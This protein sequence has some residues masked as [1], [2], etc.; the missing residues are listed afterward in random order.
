M[1]FE[2]MYGLFYFLPVKNVGKV[3]FSDA[4]TKVH[5]LQEVT[6]QID[7]YGRRQ[8]P[9]YRQCAI[10]V[11]S[12]QQI[13][14]I[15]YDNGL[16]GVQRTYRQIVEIFRYDIIATIPVQSVWRRIRA[17]KGSMDVP[18]A[19]LRKLERSQLMS[20][21][22]CIIYKNEE[23]S[24]VAWEP[25]KFKYFAPEEA[26]FQFT[27]SN[28]LNYPHYKE[29]TEFC[30]ELKYDKVYPAKVRF[31]P[32]ARGS[33]RFEIWDNVVMVSMGHLFEICNPLITGPAEEF[34]R[35]ACLRCISQIRKNDCYW[36]DRPFYASY[37]P[38]EWERD[39]WLQWDPMNGGDI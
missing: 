30:R 1:T 28:D 34:D 6:A 7:T 16:Y 29:I 2:E 39:R 26:Y 15:W 9:G 22:C 18:G 20:M 10:V 35:E 32:D 17:H 3:V 24:F 19:A 11:C 4:H 8:G 5:S 38:C 31:I 33:Y 37:D 12:R 25:G 23:G 13:Y 21:D 27:E 36:V 14:L